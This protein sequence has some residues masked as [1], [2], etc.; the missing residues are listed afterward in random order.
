MNSS[1]FAASLMDALRAGFKKEAL[2][3]RRNQKKG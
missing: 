1:V 3:G 2:C